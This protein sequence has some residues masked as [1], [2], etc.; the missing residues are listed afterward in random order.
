[1][2]CVVLKI[3]ELPFHNPFFP[4]CE[5]WTR[6]TSCHFTY[7]LLNCVENSI[8]DRG[9]CVAWNYKCSKK[10]RWTASRLVW[11]V[12][13]FKSLASWFWPD[14]WRK[15]RRMSVKYVVPPYQITELEIKGRRMAGGAA[16]R[17]GL[18]Q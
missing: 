5:L 17:V 6:L 7:I 11:I 2:L 15:E 14:L 1:V 4:C 12:W 3:Y 10:Y 13:G 18:L 9:A 8:W 16:E